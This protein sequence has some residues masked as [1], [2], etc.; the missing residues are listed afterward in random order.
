MKIALNA[1]FRFKIAGSIKGAFFADA[2][3][4]WNVL[5]NITD[6]SATFNGFQDLKEIALGTGFGL[7]YD[8]DFF[9]VRFDLG[10]KTFNPANEINQ[11][12][13]TDYNLSSSV[14]NF[15][16]NYPF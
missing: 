10:F 13:F 12:W 5:D 9:L 2:G 14:F 15:G 4:I 11:R 7:R 6:E 1:E 16:I 8:L 3:N